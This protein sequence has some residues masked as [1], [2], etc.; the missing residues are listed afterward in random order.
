MVSGVETALQL[1]AGSS[2]SGRSTLNTLLQR[3]LGKL[4]EP[5]NKVLAIT[6][7]GDKVKPV[8]ESIMSKLSG[9]AA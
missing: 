5:A 9:L 4:K 7:A 1:I 8:L 3:A 2:D 6:G